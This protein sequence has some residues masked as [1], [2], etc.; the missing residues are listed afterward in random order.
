VLRRLP[1]CVRGRRAGDVS[2]RLSEEEWQQL[3]VAAI[4]YS[5][6][7]WSKKPDPTDLLESDPANLAVTIALDW[8]APLVP[9]IERIL[10]ARTAALR[11]ELDAEK[12]K[13]ARVLALADDWEGWAR[14]RS[15]PRIDTFRDAA[16]SLRAAL[17]E[18]DGEAGF[19]L[20][21]S[22][23]EVSGPSGAGSRA[24]ARA[25][26]PRQPS[27]IRLSTP[28]RSNGEEK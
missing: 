12:A 14:M 6:R 22:S 24:E 28:A 2:E 1:H 4:G 5:T 27:G 9:A 13:V 18:R 8:V 19:D 17:G 20:R 25:R 15:T 26:N 11:A 23:S 10:T 21:V 3:N 16:E 7:S